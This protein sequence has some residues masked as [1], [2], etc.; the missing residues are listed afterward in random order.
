MSYIESFK[1]FR[2]NEAESREYRDNTRLV[3]DEQDDFPIEDIEDEL[4][5]MSVADRYLLATEQRRTYLESVPTKE[6]TLETI[7]NLLNRAK[8]K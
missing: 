5:E 3:D 7:N 4:E 2:L 1:K 8:E 6:E